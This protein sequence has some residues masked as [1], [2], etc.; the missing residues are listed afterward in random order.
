M[1]TGGRKDATSAENWQEPILISVWTRANLRWKEDE[2][3][4]RE[5]RALRWHPFPDCDGWRRRGGIRLTH[6]PSGFPP[7]PA[8]AA[9]VK[10]D[11]TSEMLWNHSGE[12]CVCW[13]HVLTS[14]VMFL[15]GRQLSTVMWPEHWAAD[16]KAWGR[17]CQLVRP[18]KD[19]LYN[20]SPNEI[21]YSK[22]MIIFGLF[23][24]KISWKDFLLRPFW[25]CCF[26]QTV[27]PSLTL[28]AK[29]FAYK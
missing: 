21:K 8:A 17:W 5:G 20:F 16:S 14:G 19:N 26:H 4:G 3:D 1:T 29:S 13:W 25:S 22:H 15:Q 7:P 10:V 9:D 11:C 23:C 27:W 28:R 18:M 12:R 2:E 24:L 6:I